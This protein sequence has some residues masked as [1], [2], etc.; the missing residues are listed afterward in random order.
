MLNFTK[1]TNQ[2]D[3]IFV[4]TNKNPNIINL[5][6]EYSGRFYKLTLNYITNKKYT[7]GVIC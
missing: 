1:T 2:F 7:F 3:E 5:F 4:S 6:R